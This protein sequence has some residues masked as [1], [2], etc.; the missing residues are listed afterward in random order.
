MQTLRTLLSALT[1]VLL[2]T[3]AAQGQSAPSAN[4]GASD[5]AYSA[6]LAFSDAERAETAGDLQTAVTK[7]R[8]ALEMYESVA[9]N[10]PTYDVEKITYRTRN[11]A[12]AV[13]RVEG[14][15][16]SAPAAGPAVG[17]AFGAGAPSAPQ[18]AA[19]G[20][21]VPPTPAATDS[22][23]IPSLMDHLKQW[24]DTVRSKANQLDQQNK[25]YEAD[26][27]KWQEWGRWMTN[28]LQ[29]A[30]GTKDALAQRA[31]TLE[32]AVKQMQGEVEAGRAAQSQLDAVKTQLADTQSK[33][34]AVSQKL[35]ATAK[36][37]KDVTDRLKDLS[38]KLSTVTQDRDKSAK[39]L[40]EARKALDET[41]KARD[42]ALKERDAATKE[43]EAATAQNLGLKTELESLK[44]IVGKGTSKDVLAKNE[45]LKKELDAAR[46]QIE[47]LK[48]DV[49][50]KDAEIA[51]LKGQLT[52]VQAQLAQLRQENAAFQTQVSDLTLKLKE[53]EVKL[54]AAADP[55]ALAENK[56]LR[57]LVLRQLRSQARQ[58]QAKELVIAELKKTENASKDLLAQVEELGAGRVILTPEEERLFSEPEL[59]QALTTSGVQATLVAG[60]G[61]A[62]K[63]KPDTTAPQ[64]AP[65]SP[66]ASTADA[67]LEKG[68]TQLQ[69]NRLDDA[70]TTYSEV[71]RA[72]PRN[73]SGLIG[74]A[75]AKLRS[76]KYADAEAALKKCLSLEAK[77]EAALFTLGI[78][79]FKQNRHREAI[80]SFEDSL[81]VNKQ[82]ARA[83]HY[84]GI[85]AT[86][87][88][89]LD[90]AEREFK[91]ALAIDPAYGDA[92]FNLAV[93]Y[94]TLDPPRWEDARAQYQ[95]AL[96]KGVK[97]DADLEKLLAPKTAS[98][99]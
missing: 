53:S 72:D 17:A 31:A 48:K 85:S 49:T 65:S 64:P 79:Y 36:Q 44:K 60:G 3:S 9:K 10:F 98:A 68:A 40:D 28:E 34:V 19:A 11:L 80:T 84:V 37:A 92:H 2:V 63:A 56:M 91:T 6:Y 78:C 47:T 70:A 14:L 27:Q 1:G 57:D 24:E 83:H 15:I 21:P 62:P 45:E 13:T 82:N 61:P 73:V 26:L 71:L 4:E 20:A 93:L 88:G 89:L 77:N 29:S 66:A 86:K 51:Q 39:E 87:L 32:Q 97:P 7:Y 16:R 90:R 94:V 43:R 41:T 95:D 5:Q 12:A 22:T 81:A 96:K 38:A 69:A 99:R 42:L 74:L 23:A 35:D 25:Q 76:A 55:K 18:P 58:Q 54:A 33:Y 50:A 30:Q 59:K 46:K 8:R 75:N 67:L 52:G